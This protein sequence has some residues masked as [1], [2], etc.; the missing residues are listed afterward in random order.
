[1]PK[2]GP[3]AFARHTASPNAGIVTISDA[4]RK[5]PAWNASRMPRLIPSD[6]PKSSALMTSVGTS[7]V[8][9]TACVDKDAREVGEH[10]PAIS[11]NT[12]RR[13]LVIVAKG[14]RDLRHALLVTLRD[15]KALDIESEPSDR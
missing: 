6:R 15:V 13:G 9:A 5:A 1:M 12:D 4:D 10:A 14:D 3:V 11:E 2:A 7:V 8:A